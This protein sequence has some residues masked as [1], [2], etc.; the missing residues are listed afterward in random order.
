MSL[1]TMDKTNVGGEERVHGAMELAAAGADGASSDHHVGNIQ[2]LFV[3]CLFG[4]LQRQC[5]RCCGLGSSS[6]PIL[7]FTNSP[8][9][10]ADPRCCA[11]VVEG[12]LSFDMSRFFGWALFLPSLLF[13]ILRFGLGPGL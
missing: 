9:G 4:I 12:L 3:L 2:S 8:R 11:F 6:H 13:S 10:H 7:T 5:W 1:E